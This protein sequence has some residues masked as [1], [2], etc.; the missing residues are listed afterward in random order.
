MKGLCSIP[1][2][3]LEQVAGWIAGNPETTKLPQLAKHRVNNTHRQVNVRCER[4]GIGVLDKSE[5]SKQ[6]ASGTG[7]L[8]S[9][10]ARE[11]GI[12]PRGQP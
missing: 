7:P 2:T 10:I 11:S 9:I 3:K 6:P 5:G 12:C 8:R 4:D 1:L